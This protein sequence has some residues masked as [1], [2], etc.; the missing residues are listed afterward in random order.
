[1][2]VTL[3]S[4]FWNA[5]RISFL[6]SVVEAPTSHLDLPRFV[7]VQSPGRPTLCPNSPL[8]IKRAEGNESCSIGMHDIG[9][10]KRSA[11]LAGSASP[12]YSATCI[13]RM[14]EP[15]CSELRTRN[16]IA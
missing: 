4:R 2:K 14:P 7:G 16:N 10:Q 9:T 3:I 12:A 8:P 1:M 15:D 11:L 6:L 13:L 5:P